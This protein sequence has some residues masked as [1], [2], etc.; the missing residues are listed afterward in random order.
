MSLLIW[1]SS[2]C[3]NLR[4]TSLSV[5][6]LVCIRTLNW[7]CVSSRKTKPS[8]DRCT[9]FNVTILLISLDKIQYLIEL[10]RCISI[11]FWICRNN[12]MEPIT[13]THKLIKQQS[14]ETVCTLIIGSR[15]TL[16]TLFIP[17]NNITGI[18]QYFRRFTGRYWLS[19][20][21]SFFGCLTLILS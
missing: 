19:L 20:W 13:P 11:C 9:T 2:I 17:D 3:I 15:A 4:F 21:H 18:R 16:K 5:T 10:F 8:V 14:N 12:S 7:F 6:I 1:S